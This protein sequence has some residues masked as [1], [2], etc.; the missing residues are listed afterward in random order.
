MRKSTSCDRTACAALGLAIA[1]CA[2][3]CYGMPKI[4]GTDAGSGGSRDGTGS[5]AGNPG[6]AGDAA[7][8]TISAGC[9]THCSGP[10]T[11]PTT[12][13]AACIDGECRISCNS[14]FPTRCTASN[15]CVDLASDGKNCGACGRDCLGGTCTSGQCRPMLIARY[16]GQPATISL[17]ADAVYVTIDNGYVGRAKKDGSDSATLARPGFA[18][19]AYYG[20][21]VIEDGERVFLVRTLG[22]NL[23]LSYCLKTGCDDSSKPIGGP[24]TQFFAVDSLSHKIVWVD[25]A[26]SQ[27]WAAPTIGVVSGEPIVG[28]TLASGAG[29]SRLLY[30]QGGVFF[31]DGSVVRLPISGGSLI[32][33]AVGPSPLTILTANASFLYVYDGSAIGFVPLPNGT[34]R[35][36]TPLVATKFN[37]SIDGRFAVDDASAFWVDQGIKTCELS[38]CPSSQRSLPLPSNDPV[39]DV[40]IDTQAIYWVANTY[41]AVNGSGTAVWKMVR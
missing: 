5:M 34:G 17:G 22:S 38:T 33:V 9:Q 35:E 20:A 7:S 40:A 10:T 39:V 11:G 29:G 4:R 1:A 24:Y 15:A 8:D 18:S 32:T 21:S 13:S 26:P 23:Q 41:D 25:Y 31:S 14:T 2:Q 30:A 27:L 36:P 6:D 3:G 19:S 28:G 37:P 16:L 12:G